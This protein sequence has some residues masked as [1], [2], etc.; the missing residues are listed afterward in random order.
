MYS[1]LRRQNNNQIDE[2][3]MLKLSLNDSPEGQLD[4]QMSLLLSAIHN[5][6]I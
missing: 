1:F 6:K 2:L 5:I 3:D 4:N